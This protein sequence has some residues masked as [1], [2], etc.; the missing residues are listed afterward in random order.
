MKAPEL[1]HD[2]MPSHPSSY[3]LLASA[4]S[5]KEGSL[6]IF[7][8]ITITTTITT[9]TTTTTITIIITTIITII[10][11]INIITT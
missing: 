11:I 4:P 3:L 1:K 5:P 10:T 6:L 7:S 9:T 2:G 8:I